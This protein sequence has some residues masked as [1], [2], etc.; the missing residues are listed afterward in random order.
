MSNF[1]TQNICEDD[2]QQFIGKTIYK[3]DKN[4]ERLETVGMSGD[5]YYIDFNE[6]T[7]ETGSPTFGVNYIKTPA[8]GFGNCY[9]GQQEG[10]NINYIY[11]PAKR[12]IPKVLDEEGYVVEDA[13]EFPVTLVLDKIDRLELEKKREGA[14]YPTTFNADKYEIKDIICLNPEE[15]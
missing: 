14:R 3:Y 1:Q 10:E 13:K 7:F 15:Y 11:C 12:T 8:M 9:K 5:A 4:E 2:V 6:N